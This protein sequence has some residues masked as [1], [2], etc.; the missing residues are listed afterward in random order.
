M[1]QWLN[2]KRLSLLTSFVIQHVD[3]SHLCVMAY[4]G[5]GLR[6]YG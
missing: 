2:D 1:Q 6:A 5:A 3:V 4:I